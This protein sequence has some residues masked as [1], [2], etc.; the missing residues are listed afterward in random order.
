MQDLKRV[1]LQ[2]GQESFADSGGLFEFGDGVCLQAPQLITRSV[3]AT[4][5]RDGCYGVQARR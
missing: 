2:R 5:L 1:V 4:M 3:M